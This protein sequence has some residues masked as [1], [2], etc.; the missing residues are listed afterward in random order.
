MPNLIALRNPAIPNSLGNAWGAG[1]SPSTVLQVF[2]RNFINLA[3]GL[4]GLYFFMTVIIGGYQYITAGGDKESVQK[5]TAR[6][7]NGVIGVAILLSVF[8]II[9]FVETIFGIPILQV[10]IPGLIPN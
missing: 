8:M 5:A 9:W 7:R 1:W 4:G 10:N 2:L 3:L 6:I